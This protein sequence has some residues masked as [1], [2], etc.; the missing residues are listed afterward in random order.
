MRSKGARFLGRLKRLWQHVDPTALYIPPVRAYNIDGQ[1]KCNDYNS[2]SISAKQ[3]IQIIKFDFAAFLML[4]LFVIHGGFCDGTAAGVWVFRDFSMPFASML[5]AAAPLL[6]ML[7]PLLLLPPPG[8]S[9]AGTL[10]RNFS[11]IN[12]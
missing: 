12:I 7:L 1:I 3:N 11:F 10:G 4:L 5:F 6:L 8:R 9:T 2:G